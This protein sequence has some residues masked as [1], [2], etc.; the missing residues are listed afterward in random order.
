ML[1]LIFEGVYIDILDKGLI[2]VKPYLP[3]VQLFRLD[4]GLKE[5]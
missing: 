1:R 2:L 4:D 5:E 3:F